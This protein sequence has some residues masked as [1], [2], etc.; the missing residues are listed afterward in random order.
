MSIATANLMREANRNKT[1]VLFLLALLIP[2]LARAETPPAQI[3]ATP[4]ENFALPYEITPMPV[5]IPAQS[6]F[7]VRM[8]DRH[9][10]Y[11][12]VTDGRQRFITDWPKVEIGPRLVDDGILLFNR[13]RHRT[14]KR[15]YVLFPEG[16][17][18]PVIASNP[19]TLTLAYPGGPKG[20]QV[21]VPRES[22]DL[23]DPN[24][25]VGP[26]V[27]L[28]ELRER[29]GTL[30]P[31]NL[32]PT[33]AAEALLYPLDQVQPIGFRVWLNGNHYAL[34]AKDPQRRYPSQLRTFDGA[35][36]PI[37]AAEETVDGKLARLLLGPEATPTLVAASPEGD[38][39][40]FAP[41]GTKLPIIPLINADSGAIVAASL[42]EGSP[43]PL[44]GTMRWRLVSL[45]AADE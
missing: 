32:A 33:R 21:T 27:R 23:I 30:R 11:Y 4:K 16:Q 14:V 45:I 40:A 2:S 3:V 7:V 10:W 9:R 41:E 1:R 34:L 26:Q 31:R 28:Q 25:R 29:F 18:Y 36:L 8:E 44:S 17:T 19:A 42:P 39:V 15:I 12:E 37:Y 43:F 35:I 13:S 38:P 22:F 24:Q 20:D 6:T 5:Y